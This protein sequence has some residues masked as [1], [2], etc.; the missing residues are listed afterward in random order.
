MAANPQ[1][2]GFQPN[3]VQVHDA[4]GFQLVLMLDNTVATKPP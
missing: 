2:I 3:A 1:S 4:V